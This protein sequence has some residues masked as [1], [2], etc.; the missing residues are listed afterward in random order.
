MNQT[1]TQ[2][3]QDKLFDFSMLPGLSVC[4]KIMRPTIFIVLLLSLSTALSAQQELGDCVRARFNNMDSLIKKG[5][6]PLEDWVECVINKPMPPLVMRTIDGDTIRL[7]DLSGKVIVLNFWSIDCRPCIAEMPG[8]NKLV[9]DFRDK[10]VVFL[11]MTW[12]TVKRLREDFFPRFHFDFIIIPDV[13]P[14]I[15][16]VWGSGFPTTYIL[17]KKGIIKK[18]W[19]AGRTDEKAGKE[20]YEKA[21]ETIDKLL[22]AG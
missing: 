18:A 19:S 20:Y 16:R 7:E 1:A 4:Q 5:K 12:E 22:K 8:M 9:K 11:A 15:G 21:K 13:M 14:L 10:D 17:N 3:L 2:A 6:N